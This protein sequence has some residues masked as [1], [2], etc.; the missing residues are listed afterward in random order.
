MAKC[1]SDNSRD[2]KS[3]TKRLKDAGIEA[4]AATFLQLLKVENPH[5]PFKMLL[6]GEIG[7]GKTSFLNLLY[8]CAT[9]QALGCGFGNEGLEYFRQ[10]NHIKLENTQSISDPMESKTNAATLYNVEVG[11]L[12]VG[13]IDTPGFGDSRGL[14]QD[15]INV[16]RIIEVLEKEEY[17]N[18]VCLIINGRQARASASLQY[19]LTEITAIQVTKGDFSK[20][21]YH[22]QQHK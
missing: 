6:I 16:K 1:S 8:N 2:G 20:C 21:H 11:E 12:K 18:C 19:V 15:E 17:I 4:A 5:Y 9:V 3:L 22:L 7:S 10:F 13:I 14:K